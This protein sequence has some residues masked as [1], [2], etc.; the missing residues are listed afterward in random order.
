MFELILTPAYGRDYDSME[1]VLEHY[2]GGK[3]FV[4]QPQGCYISKR[5]VEEN[6]VVKFRYRKLRKVF[7]L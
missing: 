7:Y 3:D 6:R 2:H 5:D 1:A 4:L